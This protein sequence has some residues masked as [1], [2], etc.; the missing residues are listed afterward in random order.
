M[1]CN[2]TCVCVC[3]QLDWCDKISSGWSEEEWSTHEL[4][5]ASW[6]WRISL[7]SLPVCVCVCLCVCLLIC[8]KSKI[9]S[10]L[11]KVHPSQNISFLLSFSLCQADRP[12]EPDWEW[13]FEKQQWWDCSV[14]SAEHL[15]DSQILYCYTFL[16]AGAK[17]KP[18]PC[19]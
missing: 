5:A 1:D 7:Q 14:L 16:K 10:L 2:P 12:F 11:A 18:C 9:Y 15:I 17:V 4:D 13:W 3:L 8:S 19:L 6:R